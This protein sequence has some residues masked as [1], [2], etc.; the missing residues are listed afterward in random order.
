MNGQPVGV[1]S[2][3]E[4]VQAIISN[5]ESRATDILGERYD[6]DGEVSIDEVYATPAD[7]SDAEQ[8]EDILFVNVGAV[9]QAYTL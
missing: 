5:V 6:Y 4:E 9:I 2:S 1:V 3:E 8:E 7:L